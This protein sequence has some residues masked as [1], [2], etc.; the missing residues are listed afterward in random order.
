MVVVVVVVARAMVAAVWW[1]KWRWWWQH[2]SGIGV[3]SSVA[4]MEVKLVVGKLLQ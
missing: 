1:L 3:G 2:D 4:V